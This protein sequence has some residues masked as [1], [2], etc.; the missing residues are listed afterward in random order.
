MPSNCGEIFERAPLA[1][2]LAD[3]E[4]SISRDLSC[5]GDASELRSYNGYPV[6]LQAAHAD[7][8]LVA[9]VTPLSK[10]LEGHSS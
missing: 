9:L 1:G 8:D 10:Q 3:E 4:R 5:S 2:R 6:K 7:D